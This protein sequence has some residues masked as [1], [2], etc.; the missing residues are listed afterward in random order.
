MDDLKEKS[1]ACAEKIAEW[2]VRDQ[3]PLSQSVHGAGS[4]HFH[5]IGATLER[6][7]AFEWNHAF[8]SMGMCS[9]AKVFGD[10]RFLTAAEGLIAHL[11]TLQIFDPFL[12]DA[13]GAIRETTPLTNWCY[14]RDALSGAWGFLDYYRTTGKREYLDRALL[15]GEWFLKHGLD[16]TLWPRWGVEF[17]NRPLLGNNPPMRP[18]L[19][20]C[21]HGGC[22]NFFYHLH[23]VSGDEKWIGPFFEHIA[24]YLCSNIQQPD[25]YFR[26]VEKSTGMISPNDPQGD[27]HKA[28]DDLSTLGLLCAYKVFGKKTYADSI[29]KFLSAV[30]SHQQPDGHFENSCA[31]IPVVLNLIHEAKDILDLDVPADACE[32]A[33]SALLGRQILEGNPMLVGGIDEMNENNVCIRSTGY[34]LI[35][36]LKKFG[37]DDRY[38]SVK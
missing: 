17:E 1:L 16:E 8:V 19:H 34:A 9:A 36:L 15:W 33:L 32:K 18:D 12:P 35:Y 11:K 2:V 29:R 31:G 13:Y 5:V 25:G 23:R 14:V 24:D 30:F 4:I 3:L 37:G 22:L 28:N 7:S 38:L 26:T 21:F 6:V 20:G 10:E 27:L